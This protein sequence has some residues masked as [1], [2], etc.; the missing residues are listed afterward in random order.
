MAG[1]WEQGKSSFPKYFPCQPS[2]GRVRPETPGPSSTGLLV[3][4]LCENGAEVGSAMLG[5]T[6]TSGTPIRVVWGHA[7]RGP[8]LPG[9]GVCSV[10]IT[11]LIATSRPLKMHQCLRGKNFRRSGKFIT[12]SSLIRRKGVFFP[13]FVSNRGKKRLFL[14]G[15]FPMG[16]SRGANRQCPNL[17]E[18]DA[19]P[20]AEKGKL[21]TYNTGRG[22]GHHQGCSSSVLLR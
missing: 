19:A 1:G 10:P 12:L 15:D 2:P 3:A 6:G 13:P 20:A 14:P 22:H 11:S 21:S 9:A 4:M 5:R 8:D 17:G 7:W 16:L 18:K